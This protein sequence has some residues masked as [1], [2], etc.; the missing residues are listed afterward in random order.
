MSGRCST[1]ECSIALSVLLPNLPSVRLF[2]CLSL[3]SPVCLN[4]L[5]FECLFGFLFKAKDDQSV[6]ARPFCLCLSLFRPTCRSLCQ[7]ISLSL[8]SFCF[9]LPFGLPS[10]LSASALL[11]SFSVSFFSVGC[12]IC[13]SS[14]CQLKV[15]DVFANPSVPF[16]QCISPSM[17]PSVSLS[18]SLRESRSLS[19]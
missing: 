15:A 8:C 18:I 14:Y 3:F 5:S 17:C 4:F 12:R 16:Y 10:T 11:L 1:K 6:L 7:S 19:G 2:V 13:G 9:S